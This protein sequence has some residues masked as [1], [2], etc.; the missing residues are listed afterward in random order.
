MKL[1]ATNP[2]TWAMMPPKKKKSRGQIYYCALHKVLKFS[3]TKFACFPCTRNRPHIQSDSLTRLIKVISHWPIAT[4][5]S[6]P[7]KV[8]SISN[9]QART[10]SASPYATLQMNGHAWISCCWQSGRRTVLGTVQDLHTVWRGHPVDSSSRT[11]ER[12]Q[13]HNNSGRSS[14]NKGALL[15]DT[16]GRRGGQERAGENRT[17]GMRTH[18]LQSLN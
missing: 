18:A 12:K 2:A 17:R 8:A 5:G 10:V 14:N 16:R 1:E 9:S 6:G 4:K 15:Q 11:R 7:Q 3:V 13:H